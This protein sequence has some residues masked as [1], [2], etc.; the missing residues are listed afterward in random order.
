MKLIDLVRT[1]GDR[2]FLRVVSPDKSI[3]I[4]S[5]DNRQLGELADWNVK[6]IGAGVFTL[7]RKEYSTAMIE[8][9]AFPC[10]SESESSGRR[11]SVN[12]AEK[13]FDDSL[14]QNNP[15]LFKAGKTLME[16]IKY[17]EGVIYSG[18][19]YMEAQRKD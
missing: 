19:K 12:E 6:N 10:S 7:P 13:K 15:Q 3:T 18:A 4:I 1:M 2:D 14:E 11:M 5:P 17:L 9:E 8:V 16:Y